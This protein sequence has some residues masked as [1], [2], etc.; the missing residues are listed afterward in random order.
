MVD[1]DQSVTVTLNVGE[2]NGGPNEDQSFLVDPL[3][4]SSIIGGR[5][6]SISSN[7]IVVAPTNQKAKEI[8]NYSGNKQTPALASFV[9]PS[10]PNVDLF[11][12]SYTEL[13]VSKSI[14]KFKAESK[15]LE[16][17]LAFDKKVISSI[18]LNAEGNN[19]GSK[20][21]DFEKIKAAI[22]MSNVV[23]GPR[24]T[25]FIQS[26]GRVTKRKLAIGGCV[27]NLAYN[28]DDETPKDLSAILQAFD[29]YEDDENENEYS[30]TVGVVFSGDNIQASSVLLGTHVNTKSKVEQELSKL[31][32]SSLD[33]KNSVAFMM[34][35]C[36]RGIVI[37]G[38]I[39]Y[40]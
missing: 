38:R 15:D 17:K 39:M 36:G 26:L 7:G 9:F 8:E 10:Y 34:A 35:C 19:A 2:P 16:D 30:K 22:F 11:P 32:S 37:K 29:D 24:T 25:L 12:F 20:E 14:K 21:L 28:S 13:D 4:I 31:K 40:K 1:T 27:G 23:E 3:K 33:E 6:V 18:L 5:H